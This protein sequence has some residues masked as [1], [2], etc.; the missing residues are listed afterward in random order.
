MGKIAD[1]STTDQGFPELQKEE[2]GKRQM[3]GA[4]MNFI[5]QKREKRNSQPRKSRGNAVTEKVDIEDDYVDDKKP[6]YTNDQLDLPKEFPTE[7]QN[8]IVKMICTSGRK[9]FTEM[10]EGL[11]IADDEISL[12]DQHAVEKRNRLIGV[13][14]ILDQP[15]IDLT[16]LR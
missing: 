13:A 15:Q 9:A 1:N 16:T 2:V 11:E 6:F 12:F 14:K 8:E 5:K 3:G 4:M 10:E 7:F